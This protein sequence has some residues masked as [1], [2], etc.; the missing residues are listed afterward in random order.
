MGIPV[1]HIEAGLRSFDRTMPEELNRIVTDALSDGL[2][3]HSPEARTHLLHEGRPAS[4][5][6]SGW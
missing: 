5:I 4:A 1:D 3:I 6:S 2:F